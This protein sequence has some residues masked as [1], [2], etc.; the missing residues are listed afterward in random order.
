[1]VG[2]DAQR[3]RRAL[4]ALGI[5][6]LTRDLLAERDQTLHKVA[7]IVSTLVLHDCSH[8]LETHTGIEV[9]MRKLGHRAVF[10]AIE[11]RE[12]EI[13]ELKESV[14]VAARSTIGVAATNFLALIEIDLG[15]RAARTGGAC[16]PEVVILA[17]T[18]NVILGNAKRTPDIMRLVVIGEDSE[19]Q[20][21]E[22]KLEDIGNEL[23]GPSASLLLG[24]AA[25]REIAEHLEEGKVT[26]ILADDIDVIGAHAL[27]AGACADLLHGLL[28][29]VVLLELVHTRI[30]KQQR[31]VIGHQARRG[32]ELKP[33]LLKKLKEG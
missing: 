8:A 3:T 23:E 19:I 7:I 18:G 33:A 12:H 16:R 9:A 24:D 6:R 15:A 21:V 29:L 32:I 17:Q 1:M 27:L 20:T 2:D 4:I 26:A 5:I 11:L 10:L 28:A 22:R 30:G 14:A 31:R 13:P 25:K